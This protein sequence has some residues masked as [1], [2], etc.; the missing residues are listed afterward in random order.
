[1]DPCTPVC[2][3]LCM[4]EDNGR[5]FLLHHLLM[6]LPSSRLVKA[7]SECTDGKGGS[8]DMKCDRAVITEGR[9]DVD[10]KHGGSSGQV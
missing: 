3:H 2:Q 8:R 9:N 6:S 1:M 10:W 5:K 7:H 4:L